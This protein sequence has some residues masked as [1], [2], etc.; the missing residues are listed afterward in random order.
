MKVLMLPVKTSAHL[1][2][3]KS[4]SL[5]GA[6][7]VCRLPYLW[8]KPASVLMVGYDVACKPIAFVGFDL[9]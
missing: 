9:P 7:A 1:M 5:S 2:I 4:S 3:V 8:R 6:N